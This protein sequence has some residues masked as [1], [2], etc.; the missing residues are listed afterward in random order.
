MPMPDLMSAAIGS[1]LK[2]CCCGAAEWQRTL[3]GRGRAALDSDESGS[4][5]ED[6]LVAN[7]SIKPWYTAGTPRIT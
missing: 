4:D 1:R 5:G 7:E 6:D 3:I 2:A